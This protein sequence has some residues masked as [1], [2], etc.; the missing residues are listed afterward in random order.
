[1]GREQAEKCNERIFQLA[2][3]KEV[4]SRNKKNRIKQKVQTLKGERTD[5]ASIKNRRNFPWNTK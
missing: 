3:K 1:M 5:E 4:G 2:T